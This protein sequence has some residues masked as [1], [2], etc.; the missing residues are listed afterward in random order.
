MQRLKILLV[1][2]HFLFRKGL[3]TA[4]LSTCY[5][6]AEII[7][8]A[9]GME[10][11]VRVHEQE[12]DI[13]FMDI[14]MPVLNGF[15]AA[16]RI[17]QFRPTTRIIALTTF[18]DLPLIY[19]LFRVG[20]RGFLSKA[21]ELDQVEEAI[22]SVLMGDYFYHSKYDEQIAQWLREEHRNSAPYIEFTTRELQLVVLISKGKTSQEIGIEL[23]ISPRSVDAYRYALMEKVG[24]TNSSELISYVFRTG[25]LT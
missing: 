2:D 7:E 20:V 14:G 6:E 4:F 23:T 18:D 16:K 9:D 5:H 11:I 19:N 25:I 10:A 24:V 15:D 17:L 22:R 21:I 13:V 1:D 8:A 12:P 3:A